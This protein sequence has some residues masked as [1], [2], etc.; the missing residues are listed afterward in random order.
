MEVKIRYLSGR[1]DKYTMNLNAFEEFKLWF[2]NDKSSN[3]FPYNT[4]NYTFYILKSQ[5]ECIDIYTK[6]YY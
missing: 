3:V 4:E 2:N 5:I 6:K 1:E